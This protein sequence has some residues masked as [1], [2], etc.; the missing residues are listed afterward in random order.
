MKRRT[1]TTHNGQQSTEE[2]DSFRLNAF[3]ARSG[4]LSRRA[5]D[6][7]IAEGRVTVNGR[8]ARLGERVLPPRDTV[9][10]DGRAIALPEGD[11]TVLLN[12][13]AGY[14]VS[15]SDPHHSRTVYDLLPAKL[16]RLVPVGRLDLDTEGALLFTT[17]GRL[18]QL[19]THPRYGVPKVYRALVS[20]S[21]PDDAISRLRNGVDIGDAV[22]S[23]ARVHCVTDE[24]GPLW[25]RAGGSSGGG[26]ELE[27]E[28]KEGRKREVRRMCEAVGH[29]V[30]RL[31]RVRFAGLGISDLAEGSWRY[32]NNEELAAV[33]LLAEADE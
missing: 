21:P 14:L 19:L 25:G 2:R 9:E 23:P 6:R 16:R 1:D 11:H 22:T 24:H 10:I 30:L 13:P 27:I 4:A 7:L 15:R 28:L 18:A 31:R 5:A 26:T 8:V 3:I 12:K 29:T 32:L 33:R 17:D 20:G